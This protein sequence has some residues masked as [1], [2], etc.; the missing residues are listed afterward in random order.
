[1]WKLR[2]IEF[3]TTSI[4]HDVMYSDSFEVCSNWRI[5]SEEQ[6]GKVMCYVHITWHVDWKKS[7]F[8]VKCTLF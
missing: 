7:V 3:H 1:M 4:S 5:F 8:M 6:N 2:T